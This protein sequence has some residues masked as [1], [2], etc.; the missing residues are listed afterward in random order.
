MPRDQ[1]L[2][3]IRTPKPERIKLFDERLAQ[4]ASV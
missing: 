4:V 3:F 2:A 1:F